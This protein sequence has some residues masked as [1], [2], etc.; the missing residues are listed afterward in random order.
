MV[1]GFGPTVPFLFFPF[2]FFFLLWK[3]KFFK[4]FVLPQLSTIELF[5]ATALQGTRLARN[6]V[7]IGQSGKMG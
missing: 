2:I 5:G 4:A 6:A 3:K 7:E 1:N